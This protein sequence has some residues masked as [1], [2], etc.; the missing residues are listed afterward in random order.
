MRESILTDRVFWL[1]LIFASIYIL[2]NVGTGSLSTWDEALYANI[3][4]NIVKTGDWLIMRQGSR[5]WFDKPPLYMWCTAFFYKIFGVS[6][7]STRLTS[8][9]FGIATIMVLYLFAKKMADKTTAFF[10]SLILLALPHYVHFSK[11]GMMDVPLTFFTVLSL[12]FFLMGAQKEVYLFYSGAVIGLAYLTKG[13]AGFLGPIIIAFYS[14]FTKNIRLIFKR[15]FVAGAALAFLIIFLLHLMQSLSVGPVALKEY[16]SFHIYKRATSVL[17]NHGGGINFYQ[18]AIFNKNIPW[19][20]M[21][22]ASF[23]YLAWSSF[24][25]K[26]KDTI[27]LSS[28]I[29]V[30]YLL[31]TLVRTKLH[32]YIMP[33][34]PALALSS[35]I[36]VRRFLKGKALYFSLAVIL[37]CM[38]IQVPLSRSFNLDFTPDV[39]KVS[40]LSKKLH[41]EGNDIYFI[42]GNDSEIFYC[43]FAKTLDKIAYQS[44]IAQGKKEIYC[45]ILPDILKEKKEEYNFDYIPI[46][47]SKR[48]SLYKIIFRDKK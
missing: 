8:G 2:G 37:L 42:G 39:K 23:F 11:L 35:A 41:E 21:I 9:L 5:L 29:I 18:K 46:Y 32:W 4:R 33:I 34:Y 43:S 20:V 22:Y 31:Y 15:Q 40:V 17:E 7:F 12:Y 19:S 16:F 30:T 10:A 27:F 6:E 13:F 24:K 45:I 26:N 36:F 25:Y 28:W 3:S 48:S 47:E 14:I 38:L 44:L 1:L